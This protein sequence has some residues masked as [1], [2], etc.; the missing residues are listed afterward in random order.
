[1]YSVTLRLRTGVHVELGPRP[2]VTPKLGSS[3]E[4]SYWGRLHLARVT[5]VAPA[6]RRPPRSEAVDLIRAEEL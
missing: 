6:K 2:G 5:N 3:I 4:V 1:M